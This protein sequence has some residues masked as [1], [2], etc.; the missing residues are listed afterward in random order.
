MEQF[1]EFAGNH[2]YL[3]MAA[4]AIIAILISGEVSRMTRGFLDISPADTTQMVSHDDAVLLD[5]RSVSEFNDGHILYASHIPLAELNERLD[6][7]ERYRKLPVIAYCRTGNRSP[8][9]CS[10]LK[11]HGFE[12][13]HNMAGGM[14][15]W[16][17]ANLPVT[18]K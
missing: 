4:V 3:M 11:K 15:A 9:A 6:E 12:R 1:A 10:T 2:P 17:N 14:L 8:A 13:V 18:K 7:L 5:V 16:N